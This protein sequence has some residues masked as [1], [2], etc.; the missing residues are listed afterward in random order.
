VSRL[1]DS[2]PCGISFIQLLPFHWSLP[3]LSNLTSFPRSKYTTQRHATG[4]GRAEKTKHCSMPYKVMIWGLHRC[5]RLVRLRLGT[6]NTSNVSVAQQPRVSFHILIIPVWQAQT[7]YIDN[8]ALTYAPNIETTALR[9]FYVYSGSRY[10]H[11]I[12]DGHDDAFET[13]QLPYTIRLHYTCTGISSQ[14]SCCCYP[15]KM[16]LLLWSGYTAIVQLRLIHLGVT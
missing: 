14:K 11:A 3:R 16:L 1:R 10:T 12:P 6:P 9:F 4:H 5:V 8:G 15:I 7:I 2:L 13:S